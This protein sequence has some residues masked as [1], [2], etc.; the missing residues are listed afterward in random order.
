VGHH[1]QCFVFLGREI[2]GDT[3]SVGSTILCYQ[4][5][6]LG[7]FFGG[8]SKNGCHGPKGAHH[9]RVV[10]AARFRVSEGKKHPII[11]KYSPQKNM[12]TGYP[13]TITNETA[14]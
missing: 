1:V 6:D 9:C 5:D 14:L 8:L 3:I 13:F 10:L 12:S 7:P 2:H 4:K 11:E